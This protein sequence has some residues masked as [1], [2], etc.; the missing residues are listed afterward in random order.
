MLRLT[1]VIL[2]SVQEWKALTS[3]MAHS[4][5]PKSVSL[6]LSVILNDDKTRKS[7]ELYK[8][9]LQLFSP[10]LASEY[11]VLSTDLTEGDYHAIKSVCTVLSTTWGKIETGEERNSI[12][13]QN[14]Y[15]PCILRV[16][17]RER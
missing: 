14:V 16:Y 4:T 3:Q 13:L 7:S 10:T 1:H 6:S 17:C 11:A 15:R 9:S 12:R 2:T 8:F 5:A